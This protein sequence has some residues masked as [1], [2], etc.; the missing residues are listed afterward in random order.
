MHRD[1]QNDNCCFIIPAAGLG[2]RVGGRKPFVSMLGPNGPIYALERV[3]GQADL[4][5]W[6]GVPKSMGCPPLSRECTVVLLDETT[7]PVQTIDKLLGQLTMTFDDGKRV[8]LYEWTLISNCDN[9]IGLSDIAPMLKRIGQAMNFDCNGVVYTFEPLKFGDE[10]WSYVKTNEAGRIVDIAE[11]KA[12]SARAVAG[13]YLLRTSAL[14]AAMRPGGIELST[15]LARIPD[16]YAWGAAHYEA[17]NDAVQLAEWRNGEP[18]HRGA[19][20]RRERF[21]K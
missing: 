17:W 4:P 3:I 14:I 6:I 1:S 7:G 21:G 15:V 9:A 20:V 11:K 2:S 19:A 16:L 10:R 12:I 13:V 8:G 5:T 18:Q